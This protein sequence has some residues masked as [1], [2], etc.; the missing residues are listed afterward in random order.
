MLLCIIEFGRY[1]PGGLW[2]PVCRMQTYPWWF[3]DACLQNADLPLVVCERLFAERR[4]TPGGLRTPVYRTQTYPWWFV[5]AC[6]Q[7]AGLERQ[8]RAAHTYPWWFTDACLQNADLPWWFTDACLQNADLPLVV[9][10]RLF[11]ERGVGTPVEGGPHVP[12]VVRGR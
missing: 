5:D 11:A 8:L 7:N 10:G 6:L 4:L 9:C 12:L 1:A 3:V 2:T